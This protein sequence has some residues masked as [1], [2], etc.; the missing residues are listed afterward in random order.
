MRIEMMYG[1]KGA[2][3][4]YF[5]VKDEAEYEGQ[6]FRVENDYGEV[7][8]RM[9]DFNGVFN[10]YTKLLSGGTDYLNKRYIWR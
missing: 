2:N 4:I 7:M 8:G 6:Y 3:C 10:L 1:W 5:C 9:L